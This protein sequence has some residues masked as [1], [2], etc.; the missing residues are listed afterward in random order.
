MQTT[1]RSLIL[2]EWIYSSKSDAF[3][4]VR[5]INQLFSKRNF[6]ILKNGIKR[7]QLCSFFEQSLGYFFK[8]K[9]VFWCQRWRHSWDCTRA[10]FLFHLNK[11]LFCILNSSFSLR[12]WRLSALLFEYSKFVLS[13]FIQIFLTFKCFYRNQIFINHS[14]DFTKWRPKNENLANAT[15]RNKQTPTKN[16]TKNAETMKNVLILNV[17][18]KK[19]LIHMSTRLFFAC[20]WYTWEKRTD[21][22]FFQYINCSL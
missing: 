14:I 10:S 13:L 6:E 2:N 12:F 7:K 4:C 1:Q 22:D 21:I 5:F 11:I 8:S 19:L 9:N 20:W 16:E 15:F 17:Q 3:L 18:K